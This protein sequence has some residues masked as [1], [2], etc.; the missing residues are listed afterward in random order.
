MI[1]ALALAAAMPVEAAERAF[2][3]QAQRE[4]Q[5]TAFRATAAPDAVMFVPQPVKAQE[6]LAGRKD[7]KSAVMWW[8]AK[9]FVSCDGALAVTTGPWVGRKGRG[10]FTTVWQRQADGGW[11]WLLDQGEDLATPRA[12]GE[13]ET[14]RAR[15][16]KPLTEPVAQEAGGRSG[17]GSSPDGTLRW[18]WRVAA[19]RVRTV[20]VMLAGRGTVLADRV[21]P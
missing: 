1:L 12:A 13:T 17:G 9:A 21:A 5:W 14:V 10:Y 4:G 19:D 16:G 8:P 2:A 7:P 3:A 11:K 15:C 6:W 18:Q 20:E